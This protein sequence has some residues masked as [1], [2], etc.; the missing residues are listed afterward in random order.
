[1][2]GEDKPQTFCKTKVCATNTAPALQG[3][4]LIEELERDY[5]ELKQRAVELRGFL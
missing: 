3:E 2:C 1:M 5:T 4:I